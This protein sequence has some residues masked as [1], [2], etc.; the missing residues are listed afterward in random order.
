MDEVRRSH[1]AVFV[2]AGAWAGNP[3]K[4]EG[5]FETEGVVNG[6]DFL[7]ERYEDRTPMSGTVVVVGGGNTAMDVARTA[8]RLRADK[9]ILLYRRTKAEMPADPMEIDDCLHEGVEIMELAA[10]VGIVS[11]GGRL[12][13]LKCIRMKLG[14][15]DASGRRRPVPLEGSEFDLPCSMAVSA[16]GQSP[17]LDGL[18]EGGPAVTKWGTVSVDTATM[19]TDI[20]GVF[21]GG[22]PSRCK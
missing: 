14:E 5:E 9:V 6:I 12:K 22:P 21:A 13:A 10:P 20:E 7:R 18:V 16:I 2:A 1:D 11:E 17:L 4:V 15:P 3:M 19:R 8:W